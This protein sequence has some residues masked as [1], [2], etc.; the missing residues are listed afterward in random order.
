MIS[1]FCKKADIFSWYNSWFDVEKLEKLG[2]WCFEWIISTHG[3]SIK[4][5]CTIF[6]CK[7]RW[8]ALYMRLMPFQ[9]YFV[10]Y[11]THW[12]SVFSKSSCFHVNLFW[13]TIYTHK[14]SR[15]RSFVAWYIFTNK[16][17]RSFRAYVII[18]LFTEVNFQ[19]VLCIRLLAIVWFTWRPI[20]I[21]PSEIPSIAKPIVFQF[22]IW[23]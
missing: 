11:M 8:F 18:P 15:R 21:A 20:D 19:T 6:F 12:K 9:F 13:Y 4:M 22:S 16:K 23:T 10:F 1:S 3:S 5:R 14:Y 7:R 2:C 17:V